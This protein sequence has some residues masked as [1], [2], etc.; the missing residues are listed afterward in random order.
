MR[1]LLADDHRIVREGVRALLEKAGEVVVGE[2]GD[3]QEALRLARLL[4]PDVVILDVSMPRLNGL[5][6]AREIRRQLPAVRTLFL[7]MH[8]DAESVR[9]ALK[10]GAR[11]Y[12]VKSQAFEDL[13]RA[14]SEI[15][16]GKVYLNPSLA[17]ELVDACLDESLDESAAIPDPLTPRERQVLQLIAEGHTTKEVARVLRIGFKTADSHRNHI[18]KKLDLHDVTGLVRYAIR[19]G[20]M[21][22]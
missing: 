21:R 9:Q 4:N 22:P 2:A 10:A 19:Q 1:V 13:L 15:S 3:G 17:T 5:D 20:L 6:A 7:S 18:M 14:L 11:G 16:R 8:A 12:V